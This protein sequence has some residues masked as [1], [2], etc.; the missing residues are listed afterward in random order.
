MSGFFFAVILPRFRISCLRFWR[1]SPL[2]FEEKDVK[3]VRCRSP[4]FFKKFI[5]FLAV[6]LFMLTFALDVFSDSL[7]WLL[8]Q[9][10]DF[11]T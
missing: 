1:K 11:I 3:N 5:F 7:E 4:P 10:G 8:R 2:T 6:Q 9:T